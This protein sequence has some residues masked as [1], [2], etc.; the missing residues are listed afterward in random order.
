MMMSMKSLL[1]SMVLMALNM[2][3]T[4]ALQKCGVFNKHANAKN[5]KDKEAEDSVM[6]TKKKLEIYSRMEQGINSPEFYS[7]WSGHPVEDLE[8]LHT[9]LRE[10]EENKN[11]K[12]VFFVGDSSLDN[13][14]WI[15]GYRSKALNGYQQILRQGRN[16][17]FVRSV[18]DVAYWMNRKAEESGMPY[19]TINGS[20][21]ATTIWMRQQRKSGLLAHDEFVRDS[22]KDG[23]VL[24]CSI[25]GNDIAMRPLLK[26]VFSMAKILMSSDTYIENGTAYGMSSL[27]H[28]FKNQVAEY[29]SRILK[30]KKPSRVLVC[31]IYYPA[32]VG[33]GWADGPLKIL[34][35]NKD[36]ERLQMMIRAAFKFATSKIGEEELIEGVPNDAFI[37]IP[38]FK[39]LDPMD[40]DDYVQRVEPSSQGG[41]K[42]A[43]AFLTALKY[44]DAAKNDPDFWDSLY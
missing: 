36:P 37:P 23:D 9:F 31:M 16:D 32:L 40:Q 35:Y 43:N 19:V 1:A 25:G 7:N 29:L 11:K 18:E 21:E 39:V 38:L 41:E 27:I 33:E 20:V 3:G 30:G 24:I 34:G 2:D 5:E 6:R 10:R 14:A 13:K 42:M 4:V 15:R 44:P 28:L 12:F 17:M 22:F 8:V 26:T